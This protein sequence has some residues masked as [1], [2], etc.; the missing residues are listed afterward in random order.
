MV[1]DFLKGIEEFVRSACQSIFTKSFLELVDQR[2][3]LVEEQLKVL[4]KCRK[5]VSEVIDRSQALEE[6]EN[7]SPSADLSDSPQESRKVDENLT[8][9]RRRQIYLYIEN[10]GPTP[11]KDLAERFKIPMGSIGA[12]MDHSNFIRTAIGYGLRKNHK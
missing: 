4:K 6:F 10:N 1:N 11:L 8:D 7:S 3:E 12:V 5:L 2:I 9:F